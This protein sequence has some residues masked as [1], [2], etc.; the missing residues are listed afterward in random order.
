[1]IAVSVPHTLV[2]VATY[3][4]N[5]Q[6]KISLNEPDDGH[7]GRARE[8]SCTVLLGLMQ[9]NRRRQKRMGEGLLSIGYSM[10]QVCTLFL[11][12]ICPLA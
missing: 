12:I 3:W 10:Y 1:M 4:T 8:P 6:F 5:P 11:L 2:F 9:K 7:E